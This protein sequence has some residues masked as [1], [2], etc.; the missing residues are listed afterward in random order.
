ML[1]HTVKRG[2]EIKEHMD[3]DHVRKNKS[4]KVGLS[5]ASLIFYSRLYLYMLA[6]KIQG[7][8]N[9][10]RNSTEKNKRIRTKLN[11]N[12]NLAVKKQ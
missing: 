7:E 2:K 11:A 9:Y 10:T 6:R 5:D 8:I 1:V 4:N 12:A 3:W